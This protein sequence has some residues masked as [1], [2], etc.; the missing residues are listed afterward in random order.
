MHPNIDLARSRLATTPGLVRTVLEQARTDPERLSMLRIQA[1]IWAGRLAVAE[2]NSRDLLLALTIACRAGAA[3]L[4]LASQPGA[5][6]TL[7][8]GEGAPATLTGSG[9]D[10]TTHV[11]AWLDA[12]RLASICRDLEAMK[13]LL[14][15]PTSVLRA[16]STKGDEYAYQY[17]DALRGFWQNDPR[18]GD[19]FLAALEGTDP[20]VLVNADPDYVL[21]VVVPEMEIFLNVLNKDPAGMNAALAKALKLH[22]GYWRDPSRANNSDGFIALGPLAMASLAN[23]RGMKIEV[24]S[25]YMPSWLVRGEWADK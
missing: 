20:A 11:G 5:T 4:W 24:E 1:G 22:E 13:W 14:A 8:L 17:V 21:D 15:T 2:P 23:D 9:P 25:G 12:F 19:L 3:N 6:Q 18:T 7:S 16:S 10:S